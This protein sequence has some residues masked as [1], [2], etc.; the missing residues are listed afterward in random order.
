MARDHTPLADVP[1]VHGGQPVVTAG[2]PRSAT[3]AVV[4]CLHGRGATAQ[5]VV[6]L[7]DPVYRHGVTFVAPQ[8]DRSRWYPFATTAPRD[9]NEP[10][11]TSALA[12]VDALVE[13]AVANL[14][15]SRDRV[16]LLGFSQGACVVAEYAARRS[17]GQPVVA[18]SG[19]LV[20]P[21]V[22]P[23]CRCYGGDLDGAPVFLGCGTADP[24]VSAERVRATADVFRSLGGDVTVRVYEG[25]G[26]EV[27]DDEFEYVDGLLAG[28]VGT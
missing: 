23:D 4:V 8:A 26:H 9:R 14:E 17:A 1:G 25:V 3:E 16:V 15:V 7:F 6:N 18:L 11:L 13:D 5:G 21:T 12:A 19:T 28:L 20:G 24:R 27:T 10:H 2:A 22:D